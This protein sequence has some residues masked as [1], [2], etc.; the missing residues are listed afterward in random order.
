VKAGR[1]ARKETLRADEGGDKK[2]KKKKKKS[3]RRSTKLGQD[4]NGQ[5]KEEEE[6][7]EEDKK[8]KKKKKKKKTKTIGSEVIALRIP[9]F[10]K[11][12]FGGSMISISSDSVVP[13]LMDS[14]QRDWSS[15]VVNFPTPAPVV[16]PPSKFATRLWLA[17]VIPKLNTLPFERKPRTFNSNVYL[18]SFTGKTLVKWM[19]DAGTGV[20]MELEALIL[21]ELMLNAGVIIPLSRKVEF[22]ASSKDYYALA[23]SYVTFT[24]SAEV[25]TDEESSKK[26]SS[27][28]NKRA[29]VM[30]NFR[31]LSVRALSHT[32]ITKDREASKKSADSL[33]DF[34]VYGSS[35]EEV[36]SLQKDSHPNEKV[37]IIL[38]TL[39]KAV[40]DTNGH[41][42]EGIFRVPG[43]NS[44]IARL[45]T[46]FNKMDYSIT[47]DDP[48]DLGGCLKMW[49]REL[50]DPLIPDA[51]YD[52]CVLV[53]NDPN[54]CIEI[55]K[56]R[57]PEIN[58]NVICFLLGFL[59]EMARHSS[60]TRMG[61]SNLGM[62][63]A[64][65]LLRCQD[66]MKMMTNTAQEGAFVT[67][68]IEHFRLEENAGDPSSSTSTTPKAAVP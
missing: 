7:K 15:L 31:T 56:T 3:K 33:Q 60:V 57:I 27:I 1:K 34:K 59:Q 68:L 38:K 23:E 62:V 26:R 43:K 2:S 49:F 6:E 32:S 54:Q 44:E 14:K 24:R 66:V 25:R 35:L 22:S 5:E 65:G 18:H 58:R 37:P 61:A 20:K 21:G 45:K 10:A 19:M 50:R 55:V 29:S 30:Y 4:G 47:S 51:I 63:F 8:K 42:T 64:P 17:N 28:L 16:A 48:N 53:A 67:N 41:K 52:D 36:M 11:K 13:A 46:Q 39:T 12:P 40:I 9:N